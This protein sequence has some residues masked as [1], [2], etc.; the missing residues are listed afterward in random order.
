MYIFFIFFLM[1]RRPP[2][3]TLFPY[4]TLFRSEHGAFAAPGAPLM[5]S[6]STT[7][8]HRSLSH[9]LARALHSHQL[10]HLVGPLE[11]NHA[12]GDGVWLASQLWFP[13]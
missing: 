9:P 12:M 6:D 4:T 10:C 2:R 13:W 11:V 3:S 5:H 8:P 7:G 1:L